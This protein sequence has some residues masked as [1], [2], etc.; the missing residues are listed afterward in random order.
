MNVKRADYECSRGALGGQYLGALRRLGYRRVE[1]SSGLVLAR[2]ML[3]PVAPPFDLDSARHVLERGGWLLWAL[4]VLAG[5]ALALWLRRWVGRRSR[6]QRIARAQRAERNAAGLLEARGFAVLGRQVRQSWS[7]VADTDE[8]EFTLV[9]DY[10]VERGGRRWVAEVKT[11][12]R[13]LDLRHGPTRRQLLEYRQ[14]FAVDGVL[15]VDAEGQS[16]RHVH[17]RGSAAASSAR[18][19]AVAFGVGVI[20]G[21]SLAGYWF[22]A[23]A[24]GTFAP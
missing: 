16:V 9:A 10:L 23:H 13:A 6:R 7:L 17:F 2:K 5:A 22:L 20:S 1:P 4:L 19:R 12:D 8:V 11:G 21:L 14:A 18:P 15:L 24:P 3:K